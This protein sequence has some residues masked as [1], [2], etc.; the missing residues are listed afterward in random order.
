MKRMFIILLLWAQAAGAQNLSGVWEGFQSGGTMKV[1]FIQRGDSLLGY[2]HEQST[3]ECAANFIGWLDAGRQEAVITGVSFLSRSAGH[4]LVRLRMNYDKLGSRER[5]QGDIYFRS[6]SAGGFLS[7]GSVGRFTLYRSSNVPDTTEFMRTQLRLPPPNPVME[8]KPEPVTPRPDTVKQ[9]PPLVRRSEQ[10]L[11]TLVPGPG[12]FRCTL[13]DNGSYDG[14]TVT[15]W[16][17]GKIIL[18]AVEVSTR[19]IRFGIS[20]SEK[21]PVQELVFWAN[22]LG[23]IPPNTGLLIIEGEGQRYEISLRADLHTNG[24]V[25]LKMRE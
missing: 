15:V 2:Y 13:Y 11:K 3:G 24:K 10:L 1:V 23:S 21:E 7:S 4:A 25:V 18:D 20:I 6:S 9:P 12:E 5:L 16:H 22:N 19:P 8:K 14:D 17:N